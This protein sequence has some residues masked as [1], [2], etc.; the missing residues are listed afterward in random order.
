M[1]ETNRIEFKRELTDKLDI[2]K[3]V[4]AFLNYREGGIIYIGIEKNGT[5]VGLKDIDGDS[6]HQLRRRWCRQLAQVERVWRQQCRGNRHRITL[7]CDCKAQQN[8]GQYG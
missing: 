6:G 8:G 3:E 5:A 4:I 2:E 7:R 1:T